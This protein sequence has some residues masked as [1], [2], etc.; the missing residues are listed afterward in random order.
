MK[1]LN[2]LLSAITLVLFANLAQA[3]DIAEGTIMFLG[4]TSLENSSVETKSNVLSDETDTT[5][6]SLTSAYFF[7]ENWAAGLM[8]SNEDS[9]S[10]DGSNSAINMIGPIIGYNIS[11]NTDLNL[12]FAAGLFNLSGDSDDGAGSSA[13][14]DG[15]GTL[16]MASLAYFLNDNVAVNF[17]LRKTDSDVDLSFNQGGGTVS[18]EFNETSTSI[19]LSVFF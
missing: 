1:K 4:D 18:A 19:G 14:I 16:L 7:A 9:D 6:L 17:A 3:R 13:N 15:D 12:I 10:S 2:I 8:I 11:L 5:E